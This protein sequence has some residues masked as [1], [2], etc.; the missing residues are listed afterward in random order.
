MST[1]PEETPPILAPAPTGRLP[2]AV[3]D[4]FA[5]KANWR[6][7]AMQ[8]G[9]ARTG[10]AVKADGYGL[11]ATMVAKT[12]FAAGC[13]DFFV[14]WAEEGVE[15]R[16]ALAGKNC[17]IFVLQGL[18]DHAAA[19]CRLHLLIPVLSTADDI[20]VWRTTA[21][22]GLPGVAALQ[23]DTG[24][25]RLGLN[26]DEARTAAR[27]AHD[28]SLDLALVMSHLASADTPESGQNAEQLG[29][30]RQMCALFP[31]VAQSFANSGGIL[32]GAD[33]HFDLTRPGISLYGGAVSLAPAGTI[34]PVASLYGHVMQLH[35]AAAGEA[36]GYGGAARLTRETRIATVG[37]G[38]ADGYPRSAGGLGGNRHSD[39]PAE[40]VIAGQRCPILGRVSMDSTLV[41]VTD[42]ADDDVRPGTAVEFFGPNMPIDEVASLCGTIAYELLTSLGPRVI[43]RWL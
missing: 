19:L 10:A 27:L 5:L 24:M 40:V 26:A 37:L 7:M 21:R 16:A 29:R 28:G 15:I 20:A 8:A 35:T 4:S 17:R 42:L 31:H 33:Y 36:A 34:R 14:A 23:F 1:H 41:D 13:R 3:I 30:F 22:S 9:R 11:G 12:L 25:N 43:R 32:L 2:V 18:D 38:Y 39:R 6:S